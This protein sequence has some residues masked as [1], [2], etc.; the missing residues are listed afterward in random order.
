[1]TS[2]NVSPQRNSPHFY[3]APNQEICF[4]WEMPYQPV[5]QFSK[6]LE[7]KVKYILADLK[8]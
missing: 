1:M 8:T 5:E 4:I 3:V 7:K 2:E 6:T